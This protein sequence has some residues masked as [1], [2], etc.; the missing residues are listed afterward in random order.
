MA[1]HRFVVRGAD[2]KD[3]AADMATVQAWVRAG[4]VT[5]ET[6][7]CDRTSDAWVRAGGVPDLFAQE[8]PVVAEVRAPQT[9]SNSLVGIIVVG[10]LGLIIWFC[11]GEVNGVGFATF[12]GLA[13]VVMS[14]IL[15]FVWFSKRGKLM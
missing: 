10:V 9:G 1:E 8:P 5:R 7:I 6:M 14:I 3:Y 11:G 2:N 15:L 4:R 13:L 12:L